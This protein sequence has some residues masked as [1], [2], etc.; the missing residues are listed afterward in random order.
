LGNEVRK[1]VTEWRLTE[2]IGKCITLF[3][4]KEENLGDKNNGIGWT[5][6]GNGKGGIKKRITKTEEITGMDLGKCGAKF[7]ESFDERIEGWKRKG[8]PDGNRRR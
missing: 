5:M 7:S 3:E 2:M 1:E 6:F 8:I 4:S